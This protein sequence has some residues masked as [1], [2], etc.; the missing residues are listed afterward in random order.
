MT[1][2]FALGVAC[3]ALLGCAG[4]AAE[5]TSGPQPGDKVK[6]FNPF[7]VNGPDAGESRCQV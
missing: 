7:N 2:R 1:S 5:F 6:A 4:H 3:A